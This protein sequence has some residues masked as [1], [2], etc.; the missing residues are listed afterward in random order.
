MQTLT[1]GRIFRTAAALLIATC[2]VAQAACGGR[3]TVPVFSSLDTSRDVVYGSNI[4]I[5]GVLD[6]LKCDVYQ[7]SGDTAHARPLIVFIHGG[8]FVA[9]SKTSDD[10][11]LRFCAEFARRGYVTASIDYRLGIES[12]FPPEGAYFERADYRALQDAKAAVRFFRA[13]AAAYRIDM[14]LVFEGGTSAGAFAAIHHAYLDQSEVPAS[15]D[16]NV[17][18]NIEGASGSPGYSSRI[19][20]VINCWG[21]IGDTLW[22]G[23]GNVPVIS[24][25][26]LQDSVVPFNYGSIYWGYGYDILRV[27][28]SASIYKRAQDLGIYS[29]LRLFDNTGH[30]FAAIDPHMDTTVAM[31][32]DFLASIVNCDSGKIAVR[33]SQAQKRTGMSGWRIRMGQNSYAFVAVTDP[34]TLRVV[35]CEGRTVPLT[36]ARDDRSKTLVPRSEFSPGVYYIVDKSNPGTRAAAIVLGA[37]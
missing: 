18:G 30:G 33:Y 34:G 11:I 3:F 2:T 14:G 8:S 4:D 20:A 25:A 10:V 13:H 36:F 29:R 9:G 19:R 1:Q 21:A 7:P 27:Y 23:L 32:S 12:F 16:T 35:D 26:G 5:T 31:T 6:T 15:V 37:R 28:G 17:L 24:F 22:I